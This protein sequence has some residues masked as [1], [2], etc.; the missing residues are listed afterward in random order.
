MMQTCLTIGAGAIGKAISGFVFSNL[1]YQVF[2]ADVDRSLINEINELNGYNII[3]TQYGHPKSKQFI[4]NVK[5]VDLSDPDILE[6]AVHADIICTAIGSLG[7]QK[8][9]PVLCNWI[10]KRI[11]IGNEETRLFLFENDLLL[12]TTITDYISNELGF[13][14]SNI[15]IIQTSIERMSKCIITK[16]GHREIV[17]EQFIPII[18]SKNDL[19]GSGLETRNDYFQMVENVTPYYYRKLYTNN[20]GHAVLG[21]VGIFRGLKNTVQAMNDP[22]ILNLLNEALSESVKA[23]QKEF[24]FS[25]EDL[26]NHIA[27]LK[28]R[29]LNIDLKDDLTRLTRDPVRKLGRNERII[30]II[31]LCE[32]HGVTADALI[33]VLFYIL[34]YCLSVETREPE[35]VRLMNDYG[36][37]GILSHICDIPIDSDIFHSICNKYETFVAEQF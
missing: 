10:K 17:S 2:F 34:R 13:F 5:A 16:D 9:L 30:G 28:E 25:S 11:A 19:I 33:K 8:F 1:G 35:I 24:S 12:K 18:L 15:H 4:S 14:P 31:M 27:I 37:H 26:D 29:Y 22:Y 3:C 23:L 36:I 20:M 7:M 32:K 21:Y 6:I